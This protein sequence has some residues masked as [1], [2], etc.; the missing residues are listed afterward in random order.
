MISTKIFVALTV[1][2]VA[3]FAS[4]PASAQPLGA[5]VVSVKVSYADLDLTGSR[6]AAVMAARIHNAARAICGGDQAS[7]ADLQQRQL[8]KACVE[9]VSTRAAAQLG[10]P[11]VTASIADRRASRFVMA[12]R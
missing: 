12:A 5:D 10:S 9:D 2:A 1:L 6:G 11:V 4:H 7:Y 8:A 3:G